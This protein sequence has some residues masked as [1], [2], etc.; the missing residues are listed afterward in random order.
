LCRRLDGLVQRLDELCAP[1]EQVAGSPPQGELAADLE[2]L[3]S[4]G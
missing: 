2:R 4:A 3:P 1:A